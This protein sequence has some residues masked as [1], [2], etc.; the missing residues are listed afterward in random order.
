MGLFR[1]FKPFFIPLLIG[2]VVLIGYYIF[3]S[4]F[5]S[6]K[7]I[8][9][10]TFSIIITDALNKNDNSS[11]DEIKDFF[12]VFP[13]CDKNTFFVPYKDSNLTYLYEQNNP[14][15]LSVNLIPELPNRKNSTT[16]TIDDLNNQIKFE[17]D[18]LQIDDHFYATSTLDD[19]S[20]IRLIEEYINMKEH[21]GDSILIFTKDQTAKFIVLNNIRYTTFNSIDEIKKQRD[22]ILC[23]N[24]NAKFIVIYDPPTIEFASIFKKNLEDIKTKISEYDR[25]RD[26][27]SNRFPLI[28]FYPD[29]KR[30]LSEISTEANNFYNN[31]EKS[32]KKLNNTSDNMEQTIEQ[33]QKS[34]KKFNDEI[35]PKMQRND[36]CKYEILLS[37]RRMPPRKTDPCTTIRNSIRNIERELA[38]LKRINRNNQ[39]IER[40]TNLEGQ[41]RE[42][43]SFENCRN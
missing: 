41:L 33:I 2:I 8:I 35:Y 18:K 32:I 42:L 43:F 13:L 9:R 21:K 6:P 4:F 26:S 23:E 22:S 28:T 16:D 12:G 10:P 15:S 36:G 34:L 7:I 3:H 29:K 39:N 38:T 40:I 30:R 1:T 5:S 11:I 14:L 31:L 20:K 37:Q 27:F 17:L 24:N 19:S 25:C